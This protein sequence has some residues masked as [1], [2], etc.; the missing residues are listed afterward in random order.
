MIGT[1]FREEALELQK[2]LLHDEVLVHLP[3]QSS[4]ITFML[5]AFIGSIVVWR[6]ISQDARKEVILGWLE[7]CSV[8]LPNEMNNQSIQTQGT[9]Y[10]VNTLFD[11]EI[12]EAFGHKI[13][14]KGKV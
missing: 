9:T 6:I 7:P 11:E 13:L 8:L 1:L 10:R 3:I 5:N 4:V 2:S 12:Y 14:F